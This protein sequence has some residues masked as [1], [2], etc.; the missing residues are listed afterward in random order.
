MR[1][2]RATIYLC[3]AIIA[4]TATSCKKDDFNHRE[5]W[6]VSGTENIDTAWFRN[7]LSDDSPRYID[8]E[9]SLR[10]ND[11][12]IIHSYTDGDRYSWRFIELS[13]GT[14]VK[15]SYSTAD[16]KSS[17]ITDPILTINGES[18]ALR[19]ARLEQ[20]RNGTKWFSMSTPDKNPIILV[21]CM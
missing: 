2:I 11:G 16:S 15:F 17:I 21:V 20:D 3:I 18:I 12:G 1:L 9:I 5:E 8:S 10:Y 7:E 14:D 4:L 6:P 13:T 19:H